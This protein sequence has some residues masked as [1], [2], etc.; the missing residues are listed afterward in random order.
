MVDRLETQVDVR[1][2]QEI[3]PQLRLRPAHVGHRGVSTPLVL[4]PAV[5]VEHVGIAEIP[6][7]HR[8]AQ[9][10]E[11]PVRDRDLLDLF[12]HDLEDAGLQDHVRVGGEDLGDLLLGPFEVARQVG[13][14]APE[15]EAPADELG[16]STLQH[17]DV[18]VEVAAAVEQPLHRDGPGQVVL[19]HPAGNRPVELV[20][21]GR[22]GRRHVP[23]RFGGLL[24]AARRSRAGG[25]W[26]G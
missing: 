14:A 3:E 22:R 2:R 5:G 12:G 23:R 17:A 4:A 1:G 8:L 21:A 15:A 16:T 9:G 6:F 24:V 26:L 19:Q 18:I 20:I 11:R 13:L 7:F 10:G 25:R